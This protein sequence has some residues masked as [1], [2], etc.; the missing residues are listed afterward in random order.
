MHCRSLW[1][2][3]TLKLRLL[4]PLSQP[5]GEISPSDLSPATGPTSKLHHPQPCRCFTCPEF[6]LATASPTLIPHHPWHNNHHNEQNP[7]HPRAQQERNRKW[8]ARTPIPTLTTPANIP[9]EPPKAHGTST[10]ATQHSSTSAGCPTN[11][12]KATSSPYSPSSAS[13]SSSNSRGTRRPANPK[14]SAGSST[15][16]SAAQT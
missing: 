4:A 8:N 15:K 3:A 2:P 10:T 16:T 13:P 7:S 11:S 9:P 14:A 5:T 6:Q 12:P 1:S